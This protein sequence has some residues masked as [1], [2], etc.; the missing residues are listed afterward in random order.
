MPRF[1]QVRGRRIGIYRDRNAIGSQLPGGQARTLQ[2]GPGFVGIHPL[3]QALQMGRANH[4]QGRAETAGG[5]GAGIAVS[6]QVLLIA[7]VL[8]DQLDAELG[9]GQVGFAI[10]LVNAQG[11]GL[12]QRQWVIALFQPVQ[13]FAHA[14]ERPE[15]IDRGRARSGQ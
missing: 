8:A 14:I 11:F 9:H 3:D 10:A 1:H 15:Q 4:P 6:E 13:A 7:L 12:Q 5:Q 2:P